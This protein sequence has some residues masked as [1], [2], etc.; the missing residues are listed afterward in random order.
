MMELQAKLGEFVD[1]E[2]TMNMSPFISLLDSIDSD[3]LHEKYS[4]LVHHFDTEGEPVDI[5]EYHSVSEWLAHQLQDREEAITMDFHGIPVWGRTT[6]GQ[7]IK[8][9]SVIQEIYQEHYA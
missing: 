3:E 4:E 7:D 6:S 2:I 5:L 9:D 1:R 8:M